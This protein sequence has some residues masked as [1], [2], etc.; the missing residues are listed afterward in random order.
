MKILK[1]VY[2]LRKDTRL[3]KLTQ[4]SSLDKNSLYGLKVEN[5]LLFGTEEWFEAIEKGII[6]KHII[7]GIISNVFISGHNDYPEFQI[8]SSEGK[9][10]WE[11]K[12][13]D[14]DYIVGRLVELI[15]VEQ[16]S[17]RPFGSLG[18]NT[19]CIIQ[20]KIGK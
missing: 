19:K 2:N 10:T 9:T 6:N 18:S 11:R 1:E 12:G 5:G 13:A 17:K 4:E 15:Y 14:S 20:I 8:E 16:K 3:I 7:N